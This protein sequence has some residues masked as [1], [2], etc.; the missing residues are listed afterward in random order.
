MGLG[1]E[2][3]GTG[4]LLV[5]EGLLRMVTGRISARELGGPIA[6]AKTAG[7]QARQGLGPFL[8]AC[9]S[10]QEA[11]TMWILELSPLGLL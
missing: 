3:A 2:R 4:V 6:I 9:S 10:R 11:P 1:F 5:G 8:N 7:E